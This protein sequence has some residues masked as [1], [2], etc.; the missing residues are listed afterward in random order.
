MFTNKGYYWFS[1]SDK[2]FKL[3]EYEKPAFVERLP[4]SGEHNA[5]LRRFDMRSKTK[6]SDLS[7][8][9]DSDSKFKIRDNIKKSKGKNTGRECE[10]YTAKNIMDYL[11]I[12]GNKS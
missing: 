1:V 10:T 12:T 4:G 6:N 5:L 2:I 11:S 3:F 8:F 9:I 7:G